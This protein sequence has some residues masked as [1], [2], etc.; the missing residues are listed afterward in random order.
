MTNITMIGGCGD[1]N[2]QACA[3]RG[4]RRP[5][6]TMLA[7]FGVLYEQLMAMTPDCPPDQVSHRE[8]TIAVSDVTLVF[9]AWLDRMIE[10]R[11]RGGPRA[12]GVRID[13]DSPADF[14]RAV[15]YLTQMLPWSLEND[16]TAL[17]RGQHP[18]LFPPER[19]EE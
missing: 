18:L 11:E 10:H 14:E 13:P 15:R 2:C 7:E 8:I 4:E 17:C 1:P 16:L 19:D 9:M 12:F 5:I 6:P 3:A